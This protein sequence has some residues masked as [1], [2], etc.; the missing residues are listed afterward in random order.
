MVKSSSQS[1]TSRGALIVKHDNIELMQK[2]LKDILVKVKILP[3][4]MSDDNW[5]KTLN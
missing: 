5:L 1:A 3:S 4:G 2:I